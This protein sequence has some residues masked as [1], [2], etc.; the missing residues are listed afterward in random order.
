MARFTL[1]SATEFLFGKD[2]RSLGKGLPYPPTAEGRFIPVDEN[3]FA[4][5][6]LKAQTASAAR[7]RLQEAWGLGEFWKD[8]VLPHKAG[9]DKIINPILEDAL[10]KKAEK[11]AAGLVDS[12]DISDEDTLLSSLLKVTDGKSSSVSSDSGS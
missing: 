5:A 12:K 7:G 2:V 11:V 1:D 9:V 3:D 10:Q 8:K 4:S 6:F